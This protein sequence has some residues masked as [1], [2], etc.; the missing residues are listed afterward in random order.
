MVKMAHRRTLLATTIIAGSMMSAPAFAQAP[1]AVEAPAEDTIVVTGSLI[2]NPNLVRSTPVNVT[3]ADEL[4]LRQTN[5]AEQLLREVPGIVPNIGSA[6]NNGNGG[7]SLVDLRGLG[8][9]RNLVLLDGKRI[10]PARLQGEVDLNNI[11]VAMVERVDVT[12]GGQVTTYGADAI[13]GVVNFITRKDFAGVELQMSNTISGKGDAN[14]FRADLTI[15]ANFDDG[16]GNAVLSVGYQET[17][18]VY[19]GDRNFSNSNYDSFTPVVALAGSGTTTPSVFTGVVPG[20]AGTRQQINPTTGLAGAVTPFNFNPFNIFQTPFRRYNVF[21][22]ASYKLTD[23]IEVYSRALFSKN[24]V[25]TIVAPSGVFSSDV[26]INL[27]NPFLPA[28][29]RNQFCAAADSNPAVAGIQTLTTAQCA[30]AATATGSTDPNYREIT[31]NLRR[32]TTE[33]G[34]RISNF[35]TTVFDYRFGAR[36]A[37]NANV[38][39]DVNASYGESDRPQTLQGY[40]LTSRVRQALLA[41]NQTTCATNTNGC[42]PLNIFGPDGSITPPMTAFITAESTTVVRTTLAQFAATLSGDFGFTIPSASQ[43]VG[44]AFGTEYRKYGAEQRSDLLAKTAGELGGAGGAAPDITGGYSVWEGLGELVVP[45]AEGKPGFESLTL[46]AGAR[47]SK[48][49]VAAAGTPR[50]DAFT[51]KIGGSW[52]PIRGVKLRGNYSRAVR[53]P[54]INELFAPRNVGLTNLATDPCAGAAPLNNANLRAVCIAQG[55]PAFTIGTIA[56]PTAGQAASTTQGSLTLIP[57]KSDSFTVGLVV[58]PS[59]TG[60]TASVDYYNIKINQAIAAATPGDVISACFGNVTAASAASAACANDIRRNPSTGALDGDP[61]TT[62]GLFQPQTNFGRLSTS[63]VDVILNYR[64]DIG[65]AKLALAFNGNYTLNQKFQAGRTSINRDCVGFY[66]INCSFTGSLQPRVTWTQRTTLTFGK[67]DFSLLWRHL[68]GMRYEGQAADAVARGFTAD[69]NTAFA[70]VLGFGD[71]NGRTVNFNRIKSYDYF[72][73][74]ARFAI[75]DNIGLTVSAMNL[76]DRQPPVVGSTVGSTAYNSGN[77]FP[78]TYDALG[79]RFAAA[80]RVK[81]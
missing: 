6:V 80:V 63:G 71:L 8:A 2:S 47:Y 12:T 76:F 18:P 78:S 66:S 48:Y 56:N 74:S 50:Y 70:G 45:I 69:N 40:V 3:T 21:A 55:A 49:R 19:Q 73:L 28:G 53:A 58:A 67:V 68:S 64:K 14:Q 23:D 13:T 77:T 30:A 32:R 25:R 24:T 29:L 33:A 15:G 11:P 57:E 9:N 16:R 10:T 35:T 39:W 38:N 59:G 5:V 4:E 46:E 72:D 65:F 36:G 42:V 62:F 31:T 34:P 17:D 81:F 37:I 43:P 7:A 54:N 75:T 41:N 51:Y 60:F 22:Q 52:E 26:Q 1:A 27:N 44:F 61:S 20:A 79:R